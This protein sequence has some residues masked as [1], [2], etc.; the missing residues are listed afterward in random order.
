MKKLFLTSFVFSTGGNEHKEQRLVIASNQ[1]VKEYHRK[2]P[3]QFDNPQD[4][5]DIAYWKAKEWFKNDFPESELISLIV[6]PAI[7]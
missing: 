3:D 2:H 4:E 1:A 6:H 7:E 5:L